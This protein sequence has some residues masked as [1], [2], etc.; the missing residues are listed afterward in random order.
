[1]HEDNTKESAIKRLWEDVDIDEQDYLMM[2]LNNA[3][4]YYFDKLDENSS[5]KD[6]MPLDIPELR[7]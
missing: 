7:D 6:E 5:K 2:M 3:P 4:W 1:M